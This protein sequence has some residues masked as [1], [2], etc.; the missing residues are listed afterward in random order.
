LRGARIK[1]GY[2]ALVFG[3]WFWCFGFFSTILCF[4]IFCF[5]FDVLCVG[6]WVLVRE[7]VRFLFKHLQGIACDQHRRQH[8]ANKRCSWAAFKVGGGDLEGKC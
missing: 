5:V 1:F 2:W 3:F 7:K 4:L 6:F 8:A